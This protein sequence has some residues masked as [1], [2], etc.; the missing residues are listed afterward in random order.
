MRVGRELT[1]MASR[2]I[3]GYIETIYSGIDLEEYGG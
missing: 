3:R 2:N 1:S